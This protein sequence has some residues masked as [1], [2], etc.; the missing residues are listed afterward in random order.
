MMKSVGKLALKTLT[1]NNPLLKNEEVHKIVGEC[2]FEYG[3]FAGHEDSRLNL[4]VFSDIYV[5]YAHRSIEEFFGSFG[6]I[7]GL[8]EGKSVADILGPNCKE[9]IFMTNTLVLKFCLWFLLNDTF[10]L[11]K[12]GDCY[13]KLTSYVAERIDLKRFH[14]N[15]VS[16]Q[17]PAIS[18]TEALVMKNVVELR[19]FRKVLEKSKRIRSLSLTSITSGNYIDYMLESLSPH[20]RDNI[21]E[22]TIGDYLPYEKADRDALSILIGD[23]SYEDLHS[24]LYI[25][26]NKYKL[27]KRKP[28]VYFSAELSHASQYDITNMIPNYVKELRLGAVKGTSKLIAAGEFPSSPTLTHLTLDAFQIDRSVSLALKKAVQSGKLPKLKSVYLLNCEMCD[29]NWPKLSEFCFQDKGLPLFASRGHIETEKKKQLKLFTALKLVYMRPGHVK[30]L[31]AVLREGLLSDL[32]ELYI[33]F[34]LYIERDQSLDTALDRNM[35]DYFLCQFDPDHTPLLEKLTLERLVKS[36]DQL[37]PLSLK[38]TGLKSLHYLDI[39]ESSGVTGSLSALFAHRFPTLHSLVLRD[40]GLNSEDLRSLAHSNAKSKLPKLKH[41]YISRNKNVV[42]SKDLFSHSVKWNQLLTLATDDVNVLNVGLG[43]R[44]LTRL[45]IPTNNSPITITRSWE[46][47]QEIEVVEFYSND[48]I[49][50]DIADGV[51]KGLFP[52]LKIVSCLSLSSPAT[53]FRLWRADITIR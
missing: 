26:L 19:F 22:I 17:Y 44:S 39:T 47:L 29:S 1:S 12:K 32:R 50:S 53:C 34:N 36:A 23:C 16:G 8:C 13:D 51:E 4:D 40:C 30:D 10:V 2:A 9:P 7:Q 5:T 42:I 41:L 27:S 52:N 45:E 6:F 15:F 18:I 3:F 24:Y 11:A 25:M 48:N 46:N 31:I 20:V 43:L 35:S 49:L 37:R 33:S 21:R 28:Q 14:P 38:L